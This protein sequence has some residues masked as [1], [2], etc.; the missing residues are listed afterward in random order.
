MLAKARSLLRTLLMLDDTPHSIALGAAVGLFIAW[1]PTVGI[2]MIAVL[3][4]AALLRANKVAGL[5]AV[6]ISNP[7]TIAPM[8]WIDYR[9]GSAF[10]HVAVTRD[11]LEAILRY[12]GW[13]EWW[14]AFWKVCVDLAGPMWI[15]G[16][17]L[18]LAHALPGYWIIRR[19][20]DRFRGTPAAGTPSPAAE[21]AM[22]S[23]VAQ[24]GE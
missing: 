2:H 19:A 22:T 8:Y 4:L 23:P 7:F 10:I 12:D 16:L 11:E 18:A 14:H 5:I 6:Q 17:I 9:L 13:T 15:G 3:A 1:T 24:T 21:S 20:V